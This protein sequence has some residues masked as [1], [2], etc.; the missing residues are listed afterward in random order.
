MSDFK[1][2]NAIIQKGYLEDYGDD[3]GYCQRF[4]IYLVAAKLQFEEKEIAEI[5][6][7]LIPIKLCYGGYL[8]NV[9][10]YVDGGGG[11]A[12]HWAHKHACF[13]LGYF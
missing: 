8:N 6:D 5:K 9:K 7:G 4:T 10:V 3:L 12:E 11:D 13:D 2:R 1:L